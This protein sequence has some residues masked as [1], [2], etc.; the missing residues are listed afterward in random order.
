ML[1]ARRPSIGQSYKGRAYPPRRK[2][3]PMGRCEGCQGQ[4]IVQQ[5]GPTFR[6]QEI[7]REFLQGHSNGI[8]Q[9]YPH[10][11]GCI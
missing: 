9:G 1:L 11:Q 8:G 2:L 10:A 5:I 6:L 7:R 3:W 4:G